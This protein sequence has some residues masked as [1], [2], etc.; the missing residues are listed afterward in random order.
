[1]LKK[2]FSLTAIL[3]V[4]LILN[5]CKTV[6][7]ASSKEIKP[8]IGIWKMTNHEGSYVIFKQDGSFYNISKEQNNHI[9]TH[10]GTFKIL[11]GQT[12]VL[13]ITYARTDALYQLAGKQ[14][15]NKFTFASE[16]R[17]R[18]TGV[19]DGKNG[20]RSLQWVDELARVTSL[21]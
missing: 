18:M 7:Q 15:V 12:Y 9:V 14:Y 17:M 4:L 16:N 20:G 5:G 1:M 10:S 13:D 3:S 2:L 21:D 11:D 6:Q 8:F 19:V